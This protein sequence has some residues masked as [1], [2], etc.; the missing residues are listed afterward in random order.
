VSRRG[1]ILFSAM[2]LIWGLP[3]LFIRVAVEHMSPGTLVFLRTALGSAV[4]L[5]IALARRQIS[6][7]LARW[8]WLLVFAII[9]VIIPWLLLSAAERHLNS[10]VAGLLVAAVPLIGALLALFSSQGDRINRVQFFGLL[11]GITGVAALV[12]L[13]IANLNLAA[14]GEMAVVAVC[15]AIGPIVLARSLSD[16]PSLGVIAGS[17][18][19]SAIVYLPFVFLSPPDL[20]RGSVLASVLVLGVV[21]TALAFILFFELIATIGPTRSTVITYVNPAVAVALG[22]VILNEDI[23]VGMVVGFPL[24]LVGSIF[25]AR[26]NVRNRDNIGE[27][28]E[29]VV[30]VSRA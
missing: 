13:D 20:H 3:Y 29:H 12:G 17:L 8:K 6:P 7:I 2:C 15:Y 11:V 30:G 19:I 28:A 24:I 25:G 4:L 27:S 14:V 10:S 22:V 18:T 5:P 16:L 23:T 21:C 9:E 26:K 1:W